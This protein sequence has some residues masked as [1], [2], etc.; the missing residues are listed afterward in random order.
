MIR[1]FEA[2]RL[3]MTLFP[4]EC[5]EKRGG[6]NQT[7]FFHLSTLEFTSDDVYSDFPQANNRCCNNSSVIHS[8]NTCLSDMF[9]GV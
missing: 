9:E 7:G 5:K 8:G 3:V 1:N 4:D 2:L 6:F